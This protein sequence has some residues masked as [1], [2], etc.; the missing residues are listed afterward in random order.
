MQDNV[1]MLNGACSTM[2]YLAHVCYPLLE[3]SSSPLVI[4]ADFQLIWAARAKHICK[5]LYEI[6]CHERAL[7]EDDMAIEHMKSRC[8]KLESAE[9]E[10]LEK[11]M[12]RAEL[13]GVSELRELDSQVRNGSSFKYRIPFSLV[14]NQ[15][16]IFTSHHGATLHKQHLRNS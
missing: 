15:T 12:D 16:A 9:N 6:E 11:A 2:Q 4:C 10:L 13:F 1:T 3:G 7:D 8:Q 14:H 5:L